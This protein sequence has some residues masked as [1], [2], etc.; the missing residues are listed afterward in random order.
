[1][2]KGTDLSNAVRLALSGAGHMV[3]RANVGK[4]R[5]ADGRWFD[6]G[7]PKGFADLFGH[8]ASD[9]R[10]FYIEIKAAGDRLTQ[11]QAKFLEVMRQRGALTGVARSVEDA[12]SIVS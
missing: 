7:L 11:D 3:F 6:T 2:T 10:A 12:L 8:R 9:G 4:V 1:M 5:M